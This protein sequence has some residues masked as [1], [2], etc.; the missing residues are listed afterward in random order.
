[1]FL[2]ID[3]YDSFVH[4]LARY[5]ELAGAQYEIVRNDE[6]TIDQIKEKKPEAII[7]SPGPCTPAE[8]G[9][10]I[11]AI[12]QFGQNTPILGVCLG[13]QAIADAYGGSTQQ[14]N[15]PIHGKSSMITHNNAAMFD[16]LPNP[17]QVGRY[18]S[19]ISKLPNDGSLKITATLNDET[20]MAI[21]HKT[22]PV[23]GVQFH[24]E[25]ILTQDGLKMIK[26]FVQIAHDWNKKKDAA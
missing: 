3:N 17:L 12:K 5:F 18:H 14:S 7:L 22:H 15:K 19:L 8:A 9:V 25:S 20:I 1:M 23:Y 26:N 10:C 13:H 24:P 16:N 4:N 2:V 11:D 6:I 21:Q